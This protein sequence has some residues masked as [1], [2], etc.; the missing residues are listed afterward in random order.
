MSESQR[1]CSSQ[2]VSLWLLTA[3]LFFGFVTFSGCPGNTANQPR[4]IAQ[5]ELVYSSSRAKPKVSY[6][7]FTAQFHVVAPFDF[8]ETEVN[9]LL[10]HNR[11]VKTKVDNRAKQALAFQ[12]SDLF[13]QAKI[14]QISDED[15]FI[16]RRG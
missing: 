1:P 4:P 5:T 16:S 7:S 3:T 2:K 9:L 10:L 13:F 8:S 14:P 12:K 6:N 11:L 15:V